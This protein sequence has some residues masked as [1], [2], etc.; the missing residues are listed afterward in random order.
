MSQKNLILND[1]M[2]GQT[3]TPI[4]AL[5]NY[6]CMRLGSRINELRNQGYNIITTLNK[7]G[8][9]YAK[10]HLLVVDIERKF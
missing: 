6:G 1:L 4:D 10:Y 8:K 9:K 7:E 2:K 3:I 5:N